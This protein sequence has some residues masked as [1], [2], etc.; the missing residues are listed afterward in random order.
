MVIGSDTMPNWVKTIVHAVREDVDFNK[1]TDEKGNFTFQKIVPMPDDIYRGDLGEE[2]RKK[3]GSRNW[4]DW[5]LEHW[6]TKWDACEARIS[7][8]GKT[9]DF[10]TA[11]SVAEPVLA[12]LGEL[13][14]GIIVFYSDE[15]ISENSG[16]FTVNKHGEVEDMGTSGVAHLTIYSGVDP[17]DRE[18]VVDDCY[19]MFEEDDE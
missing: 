3:Y 18:S 14:G 4:Y 17:Y 12:K 13:V 7:E 2:E 9:V 5:S 15:G 8:D 11:W 16:M 19:W 6:G 10:D 1:F